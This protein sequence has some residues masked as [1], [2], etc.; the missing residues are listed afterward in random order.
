MGGGNYTTVD[1]QPFNGNNYY[2]LK[3]LHKDG[4]FTYSIILL[5]KMPI[6][7]RLNLRCIQ[8]PERTM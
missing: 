4:K 1:Q 5:V 3:M 8:T 2:R 7:E 6:R